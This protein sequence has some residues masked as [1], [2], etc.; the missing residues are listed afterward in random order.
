MLHG[1]ILGR[2]VEIARGL[3]HLARLTGA[4]TLPITAS[5]NGES[6]IRICFGEVFPALADHDVEQRWVDHYLIWLECMFRG[7]PR[8]L[9]L[10]GA[11]WRKGEGV[12]L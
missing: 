1:T 7:D 8:N 10:H 11:L 2:R 4:P 9:R 6:R 3:P 12:I 5:W